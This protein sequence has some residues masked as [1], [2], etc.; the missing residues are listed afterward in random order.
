MFSVV[1]LSHLQVNDW[2]EWEFH[3][4]RC[5]LKILKFLISRLGYGRDR[6]FESSPGKYVPPCFSWFPS[7]SPSQWLKR[8]RI[9]QDS[10]Y[11]EVLKFL[12]SRLGYGRD[13]GFESSPGN[14]FPPCFSWFPSVSPSQWLKRMRISQGSLYTKVFKISHSLIKLLINRKCQWCKQYH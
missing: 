7:V 3:K 13:R 8:M 10:L 9:S 1:S 4:S 2:K 6:G 14:Y 11:T 5:I 12:I